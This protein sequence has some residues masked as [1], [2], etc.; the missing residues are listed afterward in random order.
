MTQ[1]TSCDDESVT[2]PRNFKTNSSTEKNDQESAIE[3]YKDRCE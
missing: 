1:S 3:K 2:T